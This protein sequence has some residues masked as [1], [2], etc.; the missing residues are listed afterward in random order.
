MPLEPKIIR[1]YQEAFESYANEADSVEYWMARDLQKLLDYSEWRNF[2]KVIGKAKEACKNTGE[3]VLNHFVEV[4]KMVSLGSG[5]ERKISDVMLTRY[6]C[7]L[8][9]QNGNPN[10]EVIAF[11]QSYF[12]LQ[13]R[14]QELIEE[15]LALNERLDARQRLKLSESQL[16]E[17][18]YHRGID[19]Q[20]FARVRSKGDQALFGGYSTRN[21]KE[22]LGVPQNRPLADFLPTVSINAKALA[23]DI[24]RYTTQEKDLQGEVPI[25]EEHISSSRQVRELLARNGIIPENLPPEE[26]IK[27][28]ERKVKRKLKNPDRLDNSQEES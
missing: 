5:A 6:A 24:T 28:L 4:N 2:S 15:Q 16:S 27:K 7:Y 18:L 21:M 26:D 1:E 25:T 23:A 13:T 3:K 8:I 14:K 17:T 11:A 22:K 12:A 10:K 20:G 19:N 9:A